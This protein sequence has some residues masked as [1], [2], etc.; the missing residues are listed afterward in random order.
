[1]S[2]YNI[3]ILN[4]CYN[5][6]Y[7]IQLLYLNVGL[8]IAFNKK[9]ILYSLTSTSSGCVYLGKRNK[10]KSFSSSIS[11]LL[12]KNI[13]YSWILLLTRNAW[14]W[15]IQYLHVVQKS[16]LDKL[17]WVIRIDDLTYILTFVPDLCYMFM[18]SNIDCS[19]IKK[20][21]ATCNVH[22]YCYVIFIII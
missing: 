20:I 19:L 3:S 11:Y 4:G 12:G 17:L 1:M 2:Y 10:M 13:I 7:T 18:F 22:Y 6:I 5:K 8:F 9:I 15:N 16:Y 21:F 14:Y